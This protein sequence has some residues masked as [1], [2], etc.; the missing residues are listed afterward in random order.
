MLTPPDTVRVTI[1]HCIDGDTYSAKMHEM[2]VVMRLAGFD[3]PE[4]TQPRGQWVIG[5]V[6]AT[7]IG[8]T[9]DCVIRGLDHYGRTIVQLF[10]TPGRDLAPE[11][12]R[13]GLGW[14]DLTHAPNPAKYLDAQDKAQKHKIGIWQDPDPIPPAAWRAS[15]RG[16]WKNPNAALHKRHR[17]A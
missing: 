1:Q 11:L 12:L 6:K 7:I 3:A 17:G 13:E 8:I 5:Q 2:S 9:F 4:R 16:P 15:H 10:Y 14:A